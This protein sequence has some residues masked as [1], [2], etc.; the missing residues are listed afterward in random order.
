MIQLIQNIIKGWLTTLIGLAISGSV[1]GHAFNWPWFRTPTPGVLSKPIE[2]GIA[3][4]IGLM[5]TVCPYSVIE[6]KLEQLWDIGITWLSKL[7][8]KKGGDNDVA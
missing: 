3:F 6:K 4:L 7:A 5:L 1:L 8:G 2:L